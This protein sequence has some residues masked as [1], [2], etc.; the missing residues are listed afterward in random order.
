M[1]HILFLKVEFAERPS[2]DR[3]LGKSTLDGLVH[4]SGMSDNSGTRSADEP[5]NGGDGRG[6]EAQGDSDT[7]EGG[8]ELGG[9]S[10]DGACR[11]Q[12]VGRLKEGGSA[13][14]T[15]MEVL[16]TKPS[17]SKHAAHD[18]GD[19]KEEGQ[20]RQERVDA[21]HDKDHG[22]VAGKVRKVVGAAALDLAKVGGLRDTLEVEEF[23]D[24]TD[25][26]EAICERHAASSLLCSRCHVRW[27]SSW[28]DSIGRSVL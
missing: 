11:A 10:L 24:G 12:S 14:P 15:N 6:D 19:D 17:D 26:G 8:V 18:Q 21:E 3:L 27:K 4:E 9:G 2:L 25:V 13:E 22:I 1:V 20:V 28:R 16:A 23:S 7:N 5:E